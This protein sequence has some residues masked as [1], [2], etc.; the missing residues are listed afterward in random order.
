MAGAFRI[1]RLP[2]VGDIGGSRS[3]DVPVKGGG[4][5]VAVN[6]RIINHNESK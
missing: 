6:K 4:R 3:S 5:R 1:E 2:R